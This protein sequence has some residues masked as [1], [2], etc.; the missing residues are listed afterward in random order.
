M[1]LWRDRLPV[2]AN[3]GHPKSS[4]ESDEHLRGARQ[5]V[6]GSIAG[7]YEGPIVGLAIGTA[8]SITESVTTDQVS[9]SHQPAYNFS[10][11]PVHEGACRP[12]LYIVNTHAQPIPEPVQS[13][14]TQQRPRRRRPR[15]Y[16]LPRIHQFTNRIVE[17]LESTGDRPGNNVKRLG[18]IEGVALGTG[19][20]IRRKRV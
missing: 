8:A 3:S 1:D 13:N 15:A 6:A 14:V 4:A 12:Y 9:H 19:H 16:S 17:H 18:Y 7:S 2:G 10:D 11:R 5:A 20:P